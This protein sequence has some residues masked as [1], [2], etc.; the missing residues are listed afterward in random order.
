MVTTAWERRL[1]LAT[2]ELVKPK[3]TYSMREVLAYCPECKAH[4]TV[5]VSMETGEMQWT[6]KFVQVGNRVWHDCGSKQ[7]CKLFGQL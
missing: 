6:R 4:Q 5:M 7:P 1:N 3:P 2:L